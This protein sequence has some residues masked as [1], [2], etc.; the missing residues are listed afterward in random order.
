MDVL[1]GRSLFFAFCLLTAVTN[2]TR[3]T[4]FKRVGLSGV[5]VDVNQTKAVEIIIN[6]DKIP[7]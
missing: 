7:R 5:L 4:A 1:E 6:S 3:P 2:N